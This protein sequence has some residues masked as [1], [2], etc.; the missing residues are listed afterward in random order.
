[1]SGS[2]QRQN[3]FLRRKGI[4]PQ[5]SGWIIEFNLKNRF[6]INNLRMQKVRFY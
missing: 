2:F 5:I 6:E 3:N 1:L 4:D